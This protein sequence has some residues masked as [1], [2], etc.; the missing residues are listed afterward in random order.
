MRHPKLVTLI[1]AAAI[2]LASIGLAGDGTAPDPADVAAIRISFT[3]DERQLIDEGALWCP[4]EPRSA[5][6]V[7]AYANTLKWLVARTPL[8]V[9]EEIHRAGAKDEELRAKH[10]TSE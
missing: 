3:P 8:P 9:A 6:H 1:L 2:G 10:R 5:A 7:E 4:R